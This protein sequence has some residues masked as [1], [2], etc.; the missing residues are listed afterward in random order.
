MS[1]SPSCLSLLSTALEPT[2]D[3]RLHWVGNGQIRPARETRCL[4]KLNRVEFYCLPY[5][6]ELNIARAGA[7]SEFN[8]PFPTHPQPF[9]TSLRTTSLHY[10]NYPTHSNL[11]FQL[12]SYI[13]LSPGEVEAAI[14]ILNFLPQPGRF[15]ILT[16]TSLLRLSHRFP[17]TSPPKSHH[18]SST[19]SLFLT[20]NLSL[21]AFS[22]QLPSPT[23]VISD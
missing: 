1:T 13:C 22:E 17:S 19:A 14:F 18:F 10:T 3:H 23:V 12:R 8:S 9:P 11:H 15:F 21:I 7:Q 4:F 20:P 16:F 6:F 2:R 5:L